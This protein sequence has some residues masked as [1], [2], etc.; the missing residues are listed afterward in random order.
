MRPTLIVT[1]SPSF[2][3]VGSNAPRVAT[4]VAGDGTVSWLTPRSSRSDFSLSTSTEYAS[5]DA[6]DAGKWS[7]ARSIVRIDGPSSP[8]AYDFPL[9][10]P[11]GA[12][13]ALAG[14]GSVVISEHGG[15]VGSFAPHW[16][17]DAKGRSVPTRFTL[18]WTSASGYVL[19]HHVQTTGATFPVLADPHCTWGWISGAVHFSKS[20]TAKAAASAGFIVAVAILA[21]PPFDVLLAASAAFYALIAGWAVADSRCLEV[22]SDGQ[23]YEYSGGYCK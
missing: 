13:A 3:A 2:A 21:P 16:A 10:L 23:P 8:T 9:S 5:T 22:K 19:T 20:E 17:K 14:D 6:A 15:P 1:N 7:G 4:S 11:R 18:A 12:G